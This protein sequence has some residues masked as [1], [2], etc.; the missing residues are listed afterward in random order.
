[1]KDKLLSIVINILATEIESKSKYDDPTPLR[2]AIEILE[3]M[4]GEADGRT[5]NVCEDHCGE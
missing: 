4:K 5:E 3:A 2:L 1:M